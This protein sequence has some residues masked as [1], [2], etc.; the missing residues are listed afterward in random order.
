VL[1]KTQY[2]LRISLPKTWPW[3]HTSA[4]MQI[5]Q[6]YLGIGFLLAAAEIFVLGFFLL[7]AGLAF[8]ATGIF[9]LFVEGLPLQLL[10]LGA[11]LVITY[12]ASSKLRRSRKPGLRTN[13]DNLI[14]QEGI[15]EEEINFEK[16]T[17]YVKI[18]GDSWRALAAAGLV[19]APGTRVRVTS[20]DGNKIHVKKEE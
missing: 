3:L 1:F 8:A 12:L 6:I 16:N 17:G 4:T 10:F 7:P 18:Y 19:I 13:V 5:W 11:M 9:A 15:V 2:G 20:V 14:N